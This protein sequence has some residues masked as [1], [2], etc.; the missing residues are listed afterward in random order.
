MKY[1]RVLSR[2]LLIFT[3]ALPIVIFCLCGGYALYIAFAVFL[4]EISHLAALKLCG[5]R[6]KSFCPAPFGLCISYD[7]SGISLCGELFVSAAGCLV[8]LL[9]TA[10]S[11]ICYAAFSLDFLLFG[12]VNAAAATLNLMPIYPLDGHRILC[13]LLSIVFNPVFAERITSI[14]SYICGFALFV[15][16]SYCLLTGACGIYPLLFSVYVFASNAKKLS[17]GAYF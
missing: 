5:G 17:Q 15:F 9:V 14:I 6:V 4:H 11:V 16:S 8:N 2:A 13:T 7:T 3:S 1:T 10:L 12:V